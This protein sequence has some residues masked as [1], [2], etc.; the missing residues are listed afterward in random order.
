MLGNLINNGRNLSL[1]DNGLDIKLL[2]ASPYLWVYFVHRI[3]RHPYHG[4]CSVGSLGL[5]A[6]EIPVLT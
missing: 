3:F 2:T 4:Y 1:K 6:Y 5:V